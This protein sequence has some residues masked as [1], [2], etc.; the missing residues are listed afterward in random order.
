MEKR[1]KL[2]AFAKSQG[3]TY[4]AAWKMWERGEIEGIKLESGTI[5]DSGWT[6]KIT[7]TPQ[8]IIY[9]RIASPEFLEDLEAKIKQATEYAEYS[10]YEVV[11]VVKEIVSGIN[12]DRPKLHQ[13]FEIPNW[14]IL[15]VCDA[16][17]ITSI[18]FD[19]VKAIVASSGKRLEVI[20]PIPEDEKN[21]LVE[22]TQRTIGWAKQII[23]MNNY[24]N[25][26]IQI[27][28][29]LNK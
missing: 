12:Y 19:L 23:G 16:N 24:K 6:R 9:A 14:D 11:R 27:I 8:V 4:Q 10:E 21:L 5:L 20:N 25:N 3:I 18:N 2:S 22:L 29:K 17:E 13:I 15:L 7:G 26:V 28:R 1:V